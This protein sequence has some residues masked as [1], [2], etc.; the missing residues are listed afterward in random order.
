LFFFFF[1]GSVKRRRRGRFIRKITKRFAFVRQFEYIIA[2][3]PDGSSCALNT[4]TRVRVYEIGG[5]ESFNRTPREYR[6][7]N[8]RTF[9]SNITIIRRSYRLV[10][11]VIRK[12][13]ERDKKRKTLYDADAILC[14]LLPP[15][16]RTIVIRS[17]DGRSRFPPWRITGLPRGLCCCF[18]WK[19]SEIYRQIFD[20]TTDFKR[21][22]RRTTTFPALDYFG[23]ELGRNVFRNRIG[24]RRTRACSL[25]SSRYA[26]VYRNWRTYA[27]TVRARI[28]FVRRGGIYLRAESDNGYRPSAGTRCYRRNVITESPRGRLSLFTTRL[29][30]RYATIGENGTITDTGGTVEKATRNNRR[31]A[32]VVRISLRR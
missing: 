18:E 4:R 23:D 13:T 5:R 24:T 29:S 26:R 1:F 30:F 6:I 31:R 15:L 20:E 17:T 28:R 12:F 21:D 19:K 27:Y 3:V 32:A 16:R 11:K 7:N 9:S 8:R 22:R 10:A 14:P 25:A 2:D